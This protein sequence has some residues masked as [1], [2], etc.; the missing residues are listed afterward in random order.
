MTAFNLN[1]VATALRTAR[2]EG[3]PIDA[4]TKTWTCLNADMA[5]KVQQI[6]SE[7]AI[8]NGDRLVG[9]K[10]GNIA[11]VM[12]AAFGLDHTDYGFLHASS[13]IYEGTTISLNIFIRPFVELEPAFVLRS[14]LKGPNVN[15]RTLL[16]P[17][18]MPFQQLRS[19]IR[20]S[21][22]GRLIFR[23]H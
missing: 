22:I 20:A 7:Q 1:N 17:L 10:L 13:F 19:S 5:F 15:S 2:A 11:K 3:R 21:K 23:I 18:T 6:N 9:Y 12:Q 16:V 14:S 8:Q 4:P